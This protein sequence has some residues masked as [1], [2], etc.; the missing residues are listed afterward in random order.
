MKKRVLWSVGIIAALALAATMAVPSAHAVAATASLSNVNLSKTGLG[1]T[2]VTITATMVVN[3]AMPADSDLSF[4]L[5]GNVPHELGFSFS[6]ASI[7]ITGATGDLGGDNM[8]RLSYRLSSQLGTGTKTVTITGVKNASQAGLFVFG[9]EYRDPGMAPNAFGEQ[10]EASTPITVGAI[11]VMGRVKMPNGTPVSQ[12]WGVGV[13][14]RDENFTTNIGGGTIA[15]H[16]RRVNSR[17]I[18]T[19]RKRPCLLSKRIRGKGRLVD[20]R[21]QLR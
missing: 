3:S 18:G 16:Y 11:A 19:P 17:D 6:D 10:I 7:S 13:N 21:A 1:A 4:G 14:A 15:S 9:V 8:D 2:G 5:Q 12:E 20:H